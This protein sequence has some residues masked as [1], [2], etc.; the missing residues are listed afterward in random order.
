MS[1]I[2]A[3]V[4]RRQLPVKQIIFEND[5]NGQP[6]I[7]GIRIGRTWTC[8][9]W[10][11]FSLRLRDKATTEDIDQTE[12]T[13]G[14]PTTAS[15]GTITIVATGE[16]NY[17]DIVV[18]LTIT[19]RDRG[20][21]FGATVYNPVGSTWG[22]D[23]VVW[24][25][26]D[27]Y[28]YQDAEDFY[29]FFGDYNGSVIWKPH[30]MP[31]TRILA[32]PH[33][34]YSSLPLAAFFDGESK[35]V[36]A[37]RADDEQGNAK[38]YTLSS[39]VNSARLDFRHHF[40]ARY[41]S[42]YHADAA[43]TKT[44][45]YSMI[46][47]GFDSKAPDALDVHF[48]IAEWYREWATNEERPWV[49]RGP[50]R[51]RSDLSQVV[52]NA[53]LMFVQATPNRTDADFDNIVDDV[54]N[55]TDYLSVSD[56]KGGMIVQLYSWARTGY[57]TRTPDVFWDNSVDNL[58]GTLETTL[59]SYV[60]NGVAAIQTLPGVSC[61][62]YTWTNNWDVNNVTSATPS[63]NYTGAFN[64]AAYDTLV[65][66]LGV[67]DVADYSNKTEEGDTK[68]IES[69]A[70]PPVI[71]YAQT[72][73][74]MDFVNTDVHFIELSVMYRYFTA[75]NGD[76]SA[77]RP[78]GW[79]WDTM[80]VGPAV[81]GSGTLIWNDDPNKPTW[82]MAGYID[83]IQKMMDMIKSTV[84]ISVFPQAGMPNIFFSCE[85][86]A[87]ECITSF[88]IQNGD[89]FD[90]FG[91]QYGNLVFG[92]NVHSYQYI[93]GEYVRV[94][95]I[96]TPSI[97]GPSGGSPS[98]SQL[99]AGGIP[100]VGWHWL[101]SGFISVVV[102]MSGG[103]L[104]PTA[105]DIDGAATPPA[106]ENDPYWL[107]M[108]TMYDSLPYTRKFMQGRM[109]PAPG[110]TANQWLRAFQKQVALPFGT[111]MRSWFGEYKTMACTRQ[112]EDG[113]VGVI[114]LNAVQSNLDYSLGVRP[115]DF[116][117]TVTVDLSSTFHRLPS[118][119]KTVYVRNLATGART[120]LA[121][122]TDSVSLTRTLQPFSVELLEVEASG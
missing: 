79:Y 121:T 26:F 75:W 31:Y 4:S 108:K 24:P 120:T 51:S 13:V 80:P 59:T 38:T 99:A 87:Q 83:G 92:A 30:L 35:G 118:G 78:L 94:G 60:K 58:P 33:G 113:T 8:K 54:T 89:E 70:V 88:D 74:Q 110:G 9:A 44:V 18:T 1:A 56:T 122:F 111:F 57:N 28:P 32:S 117:A 48:D 112:A 5:G 72:S 66:A 90:I 86:T 105:Q 29:A 103:A 53:S 43:Q 3:K 22:V 67:V 45:P 2:N 64:H 93:F 65:P 52:K 63:L 11:L 91:Y 25:C 27:V 50:W 47:E 49:Q 36:L 106:H 16:G 17:A 82:S 114:L 23:S 34:G 116:T 10:Q 98:P 15:D 96:V 77:D 71:P 104:V 100:A 101:V 115:L 107:W 62:V 102:R 42:A 40:P 41:L 12:F 19:E 39:N 37:F 81:I 55:L 76:A 7:A 14:A 119:T 6:R 61:V 46:L 109:L 97:Y 69:I 95:N 84:R 73:S 68:L 85:G 20:F 21:A